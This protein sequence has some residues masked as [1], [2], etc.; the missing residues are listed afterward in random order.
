MPCVVIAT[1]TQYQNL[2]NLRAK[3]SLKT[4]GNAVSKGHKIVVVDASPQSVKDAFLN[5]GGTVIQNTGKTMGESRRQAISEATKITAD[6]GIIAW[7]EPEKENFIQFLAMIAKRMEQA[8]IGL[9]IPWRISLKSY[10]LHQQY[11]EKLGN[12]AFKLRTGFPLDMWFGPRIFTRT[13][14]HFF[15]DYKGEHGDKWDSI[16]VPILRAIK[17]GIAIE[18][19]AVDFVYPLEQKEA[20]ENSFIFLQKRIEQLTGLVQAINQ[21]CKVLGIS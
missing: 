20:E 5:E 17:S 1:T 19:V 8:S 11:A 16:F 18:S 13:I 6:D 3:L 2:D 7:V 10:P 21:E 9:V 14:A 4:I 12:E 15:L